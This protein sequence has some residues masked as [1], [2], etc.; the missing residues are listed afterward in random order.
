MGTVDLVYQMTDNYTVQMNSHYGYEYKQPQ[1]NI[2]WKST[3]YVLSL[4]ITVQVYLRLLVF[5]HNSPNGIHIHDGPGFLSYNV[6]FGTSLIVLSTF[7]T[8]IA[9]YA[10]YLGT[11]LRTFG[12]NYVSYPIKK[13]E[14]LVSANHSRNI[15]PCKQVY[16]SDEQ[17]INKAGNKHCVYILRAD[18]GYVNLSITT[19]TYNGPN[20][21]KTTS[22]FDQGQPSND[23]CLQGGFAY[24][25]Y[26]TDSDDLQLQYLCNNYTDKYSIG[27]KN[28]HKSFMDIISS[29]GSM[30][31]VI[32]SYW[33][34]SDVHVNVRGY[35]FSLYWCTPTMEV[36]K[37][38]KT[39]MNTFIFLLPL[40]SL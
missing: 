28:D 24:E 39:C 4:R 22:I 40:V 19:M 21:N 38:F 20:Y 6:N 10:T 29:S 7:Q 30:L 2:L 9:I 16:V 31:V 3:V 8:F 14:I 35:Y 26:R 34:Y 32:Y 12:I 27:N 18:T 11:R 17:V 23:K 36:Y 25:K 1:I 33:H 5:L 13:T 15:P 37:N